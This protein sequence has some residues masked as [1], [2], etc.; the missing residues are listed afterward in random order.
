V[1]RR[2]ALWA[3][4]SDL[5]EM[6]LKKGRA[7]SSAWASIPARRDS[8]I[9]TYTG[10]LRALRNLK[11]A[12]DDDVRKVRKGELL[13]LGDSLGTLVLDSF[14]TISVMDEAP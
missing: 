6:R 9:T 1:K 4:E 5:A 8:G 2:P 3:K 12:V 14:E 11:V 13:P 7:W 10:K